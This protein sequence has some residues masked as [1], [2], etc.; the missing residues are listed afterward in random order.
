M[1]SNQLTL[2]NSAQASVCSSQQLSGY[3][4]QS[5]SL[6]SQL[7]N[8]QISS[9]TLQNAQNCIGG[10]QQTAYPWNHQYSYSY[11]VYVDRPVKADISI[12]KVENGFLVTIKDK[13]YVAAD[14]SA[15]TGIIAV[16]FVDKIVV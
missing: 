4:Q 9:S 2:A 12:D 10:I 16:Y 6:Q 7:I 5:N 14:V 15:V 8:Q 13:K 11:P 1:N 3:N